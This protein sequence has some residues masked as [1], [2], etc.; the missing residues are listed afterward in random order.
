MYLAKRQGK[1]STMSESL[2]PYHSC[3]EDLN[4]CIVIPKPRKKYNAKGGQL[5]RL[6]KTADK[7]EVISYTHMN[8]QKRYKRRNK[9]DWWPTTSIR[10]IR[11]L[12][13]HRDARYCH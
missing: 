2:K 10:R 3:L 1:F 9:R 5:L 11:Q 7:L 8:I 12:H 13:E 6:P 4:H